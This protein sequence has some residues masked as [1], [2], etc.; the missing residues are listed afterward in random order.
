MAVVSLNSYVDIF[1]KVEREKERKERKENIRERVRFKKR[2][3]MPR[4][5]SEH[6][7]LRADC[8]RDTNTNSPTLATAT[9][10]GGVAARPFEPASTAVAHTDA[11]KAAAVTTVE[12][13]Y[14]VFIFCRFQILIFTQFS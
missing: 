2:K 11:I 9:Y 12:G 1:I 5:K 13:E 7:Q 14:G 10:I 6:E 8:D 3:G 4:G